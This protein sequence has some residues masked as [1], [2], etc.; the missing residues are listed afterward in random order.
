MHMLVAYLLSGPFS[1]LF[2]VPFLMLL[3]RHPDLL[4]YRSDKLEKGHFNWFHQTMRIQLQMSVRD[5]GEHLVDH[6]RGGQL[7]H[8]EPDAEQRQEPRR[9]RRRRR[10]REWQHAANH[11]TCGW[12]NLARSFSGC[13]IPN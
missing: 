7:L 11:L 3:N 1:V 4:R 8:A 13:V 9:G 10:Q 2:S 5:L 12:G 6:V